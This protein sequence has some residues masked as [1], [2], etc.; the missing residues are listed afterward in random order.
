M[1]IV[2]SVIGIYAVFLDSRGRMANIKHPAQCKWFEQ[3]GTILALGV[4]FEIKRK[5]FKG[6]K[7]FNYN[8]ICE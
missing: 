7:D 6:S 8:L 3:T 5:T 2:V 4:G 1:L